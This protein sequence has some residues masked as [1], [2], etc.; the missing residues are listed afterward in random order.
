MACCAVG[1]CGRR[2]EAGPGPGLV[3]LRTRDDGT[4]FVCDVCYVLPVKFRGPG[5]LHHDRAGLAGGPRLKR[6]TFLEEE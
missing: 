3:P 1:P 4:V 5:K 6:A 2:R